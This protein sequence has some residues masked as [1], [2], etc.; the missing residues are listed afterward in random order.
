MRDSGVDMSKTNFIIVTHGLTLRLF[1]MRWLQVEVEEFEDMYSM[2][3]K[4]GEGSFG[5]VHRISP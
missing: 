1:L 4:I 5:K 2:G 3:E